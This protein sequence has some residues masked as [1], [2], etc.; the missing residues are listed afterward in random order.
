MKGKS[1]IHLD[2][3]EH[4]I[5]EHCLSPDRKKLAAAELNILL[6]IDVDHVEAAKAHTHQAS[7]PIQE[8]ASSTDLDPVGFFY[9]HNISS[10]I[11][12]IQHCSHD[13]S[14]TSNPTLLIT[15]TEQS[16]DHNLGATQ[17]QIGTRSRPRPR[18][19]FVN[20]RK[21]SSSDVRVARLLY[22]DAKSL[23]D[24]SN[25]GDEQ[26]SIPQDQKRTR[27]DQSSHMMAGVDNQ[28]DNIIHALI[29]QHEPPRTAVDD[30]RVYLTSL[31]Q[32]PLTHYLS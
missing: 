25:D 23:Q 16:S 32:T 22:S 5:L 30:L 14:S 1:G 4:V 2:N 29:A 10:L 19:I 15:Y 27:A 28:V 13:Y 18:P 6:V 31:M 3:K 11:Y 26:L 9:R 17:S 21:L 12:S 7:M 20:K 8:K 24:P